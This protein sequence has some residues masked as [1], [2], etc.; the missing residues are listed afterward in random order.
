MGQLS[1]V[2]INVHTPRLI[3][4]RLTPKRETILI[5]VGPEKVFRRIP[6]LIDLVEHLAHTIYADS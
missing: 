3:K 5:K 2:T 4:T 6:I 1:S